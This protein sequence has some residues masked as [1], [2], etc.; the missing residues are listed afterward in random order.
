MHLDGKSWFAYGFRAALADRPPLYFYDY[1][2]AAARKWAAAEEKGG[3]VHL[4]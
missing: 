3:P 2:L 4:V 1:L